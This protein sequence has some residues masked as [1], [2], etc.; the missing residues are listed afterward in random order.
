MGKVT[1][2]LE[3]QREQATRRNPEERIKDWF[4]IYEPFD[5]TAFMVVLT[6]AERQRLEN[7]RHW[8][9]LEL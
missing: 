4:E 6:A 1:G 3:I 2:F 9:F 7:E 5:Q 8:R